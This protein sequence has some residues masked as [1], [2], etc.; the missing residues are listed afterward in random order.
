MR[1]GG[2]TFNILMIMKKVTDFNI[3]LYTALTDFKKAFDSV[4]HLTLREIMKKMEVS[5]PVITSLQILY[6]SQEV[7]VRIGSELTEW[8]NINK[9]V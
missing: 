5:G 6:Q 9:G 4:H 2:Q 3:P 1:S 7:A 8:F